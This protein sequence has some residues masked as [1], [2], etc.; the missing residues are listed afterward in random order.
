MNKCLPKI[1]N[2]TPEEGAPT[3]Y[4]GQVSQKTKQKKNGPGVGAGTPFDQ[5]MIYTD[6]IQIYFVFSER[7]LKPNYIKTAAILIHN[8]APSP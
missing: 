7:Q 6:V 8:L 4:F 1:S 2:I 5:P 3:Y